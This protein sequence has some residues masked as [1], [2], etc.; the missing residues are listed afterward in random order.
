M[1][2]SSSTGDPHQ[3]PGHRVARGVE[4]RASHRTGPRRIDRCDRGRRLGRRGPATPPDGPPRGRASAPGAPAKSVREPDAGHPARSTRPG[5]SA[6][7]GVRNRARGGRAQGSRPRLPRDSAG[8]APCARDRPRARHRQV[9]SLPTPRATPRDRGAARDDPRRPRSGM[10]A[11][12]LLYVAP[13]VV[14]RRSN[15]GTR[16]LLTPNHGADRHLQAEEVTYQLWNLALGQPVNPHQDRD[17]G[18]HRRSERAWRRLL[19]TC[20]SSG[21]CTTGSGARAAGTP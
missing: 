1:T 20:P 6:P 12:L 2:S 19:A 7:K 15:G 14:H 8:A 13:R 4:H 3:R 10:A 9:T 18:I 17:D 11:P 5:A 16:G 21:G